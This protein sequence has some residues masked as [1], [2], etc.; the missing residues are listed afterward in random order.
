MFSSGPG[1]RSYFYSL[2][3][4]LSPGCAGLPRPRPEDHQHDT[5]KPAC[6]PN[7]SLSRGGGGG[8]GGAAQPAR[9]CRAIIVVVPLHSMLLAVEPQ[10]CLFP[11]RSR[12]VG[13]ILV[14]SLFLGRGTVSRRGVAARSGHAVRMGICWGVV[15]GEVSISFR[16]L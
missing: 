2:L 7:V 6:S 12:N 13:E 15:L 1:R 11:V 5:S 3:L 10:I 8:G 14:K 4:F 16:L 9:L